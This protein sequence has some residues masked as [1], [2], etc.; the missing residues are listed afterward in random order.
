MR[1]DVLIRKAQKE[2]LPAII[3]LT[4]PI[5]DKYHEN[6]SQ[7][8]YIKDTFEIAK[9]DRD[10]TGFFSKSKKIWV[11]VHNM[12]IVGVICATIKEVGVKIA[13]IIVKKGYRDNGIGTKLLSKI[14]TFIEHHEKAIIKVY[15]TVAT[16]N[17]E[18]C[19]FF[20]S[21]NFLKE[22]LLRRKYHSSIDEW[23]YVWFKGDPTRKIIFSDIKVEKYSSIYEKNLIEYLK[24]KIKGYYP[25]PIIYKIIQAH[26][27]GF[28][29]YR[30]KGKL[31]FFAIN[32]HNKITGVVVLS[33]KW[34]GSIRMFPYFGDDYVS[35][36]KLMQNALEA[37]QAD[38]YKKTI[39]TNFTVED[40]SFETRLKNHILLTYGF[41]FEG[42]HRHQYT[43]NHKKPFHEIELTKIFN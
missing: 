22:C 23:D 36:E 13:P 25:K 6:I 33:K 7:V 11:A 28:E 29:N 24:N 34:A 43:Y 37:L 21:H 19:S 9:L 41:Q 5:L 20:E 3:S 35:L 15:A 38:L 26:E 42:I 27:I 8:I 10:P 14:L 39:Y 2:D 18:T 4:E 40:I 31:I 12:N 1:K 16:T 32:K 30:K 17:I